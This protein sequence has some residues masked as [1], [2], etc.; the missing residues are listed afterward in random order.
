MNKKL[1]FE[2]YSIDFNFDFSEM[3]LKQ[4][5]TYLWLIGF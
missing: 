5:K 3:E 4:I 2:T 1:P